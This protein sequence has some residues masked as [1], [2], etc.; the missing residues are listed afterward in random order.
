MA[1]NKIKENFECLLGALKIP[2][3]RHDDDDD[4][5]ERCTQD[6]GAASATGILHYSKWRPKGS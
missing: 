5:D 4:D 1:Q 2:C 6:D 3:V